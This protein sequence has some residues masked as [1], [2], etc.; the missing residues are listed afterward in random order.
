MGYVLDCESNSSTERSLASA[1]GCEPDDIYSVFDA[2][3]LDAIYDADTRP[4]VDCSRFLSDRLMEALGQ[5]ELP[6]SICWFH[7]TR[8]AEGSEFL[9]GLLPLGS[10]LSRV[11]QMLMELAPSPTVRTNLRELQLSG[12]PDFHFNLKAPNPF[13]WGP[14]GYLVP[15][16]ASHSADLMQHDYLGMP[17]IVEDICNGYDAKF[18]EQLFD[19]YSAVLKPCIV[20]FEHRAE[21]RGPDTLEVAAAYLYGCRKQEP[22]SHSWI[23]CFD[24]NGI[25]VGSECI[26]SVRFLDEDG[27]AWL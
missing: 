6:D 16:I 14:Y 3:D 17:E 19:H 22:P 9:D 2:L 21:G 24:G 10:V 13:H 7:F 4:D 26:R 8:T 5:P 23:T 11:W 20:K 15:A 1:Y 27:S 18:G 12:V 25:P